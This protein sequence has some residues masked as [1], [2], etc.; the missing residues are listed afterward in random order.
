MALGTLDLDI[1]PFGITAI[2]RADDE[3]KL[4]SI[5]SAWEATF[6]K[7]NPSSL[8]LWNKFA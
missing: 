4:W 1:R 8:F 7:A 5:M 2:A 6:L 3:G